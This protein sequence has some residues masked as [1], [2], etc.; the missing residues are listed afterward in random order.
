MTLS[1]PMRLPYGNAYDLDERQRLVLDKLKGLQERFLEVCETEGGGACGRCLESKVAHVRWHV[2]FDGAVLLISPYD[3]I[4]SRNAP[5]VLD[6]PSVSIHASM[7]VC[8]YDVCTHAHIPRCPVMLDGYKYAV[9]IHADM[10]G[11]LHTGHSC[12]QDESGTDTHS[13]PLRHH[14]AL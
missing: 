1:R 9:H 3:H 13:I 10:W 11:S 2:C 4:K 7:H 6:F 12:A 5:T 8:V 14:A